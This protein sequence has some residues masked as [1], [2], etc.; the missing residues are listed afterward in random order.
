[1]AS[2]GTSKHLEPIPSQDPQ[3]PE[4]VSQSKLH[5]DVIQILP[6]S[7]ETSEEVRTVTAYVIIWH[8]VCTLPAN[9]SQLDEDIPGL[10]G[11]STGPDLPSGQTTDQRW[12]SGVEIWIH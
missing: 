7:H 5:K 9:G 10:I 2:P 11:F 12:M 4:K 3:H 6:G 8:M 1:M